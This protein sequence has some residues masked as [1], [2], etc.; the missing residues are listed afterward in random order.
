MKKEN[1]KY[2][3]RRAERHEVS[4]QYYNMPLLIEY[5]GKTCVIG[6]GNT[7][8]INVFRYDKDHFFVMAVNPALG[9]AGFEL[10]NIHDMEIVSDMFFQDVEAIPTVFMKKDFSD[11]TENSQADIL[12]QWI[13]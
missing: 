11:Y 3:I 4:G 7:D 5:K 8:K 6:A 12:A 2:N 1:R 10:I 9:Y 13:Q